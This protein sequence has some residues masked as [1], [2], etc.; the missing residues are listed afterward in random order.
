MDI[1]KG[2]IYY[3]LYYEILKLNFRIMFVWIVFDLLLL[4]MG[5]VL[6]EYW[7]KGFNVIN[8]F[9]GVIFRFRER[10]IVVVGDIIKMYNMI[11]LL[12]KD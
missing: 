4:Y 3:I 6:N 9:L 2:F 1:Y 12:E 10:K 11:K 8:D 7:V 5:Y